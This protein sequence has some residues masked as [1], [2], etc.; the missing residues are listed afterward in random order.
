M[1]V[2]RDGEGPVRVGK[3]WLRQ[4]ARRVYSLVAPRLFLRGFAGFQVLV[5]GSELGLFE[6]LAT[7]PGCTA[8][9]IASQLH[10]PAHSAGALL[11][12]CASLGLVRRDAR[13]GAYRN[14]R[15]VDR[16]FIG[17]KRAWTI[18]HLEAFQ[19]LMYRPF[20]H[21]A[22]SLRQGTNVGLQCF[23]G[24]GN[25]L[26]ERLESSPESKKIFYSW[27]KSIKRGDVPT[28]VV[29]ALRDSRHVLDVGG[30]DAGNAID[31]VRRLPRIKVTILDLADTCDIASRNA[32][33]AGLSDRISASP[34][35]FLEDPL[36][37]GADAIMF[38]HIF[39]IYSDEIN[40]ALVRKSAEALPK[41]GKLVI[42][43]LI[44][45]DDQTGPWYAGFMSLYFQVLA[46]GTGA[47]YPPSRYEAWFAN[48][49]FESLIIHTVGEGV[50]IGTK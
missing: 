33:E 1:R 8:E 17:P 25:T 14:S 36:P 48:A 32:A 11:L 7:R 35:N 39:N 3:R 9:E 27:M 20:Y 24:S 30:G 22:D 38:A 41:G 34:G 42:Y 37:Q 2:V 46:T 5:A 40:Q 50:F 4:Q 16:L 31:L 28:R 43:N 44:S 29:A 49:G 15:G 47:V 10:I 21:L 18:P 26:Y 13:R 6:L 12:S 19:V 45:D 23:P